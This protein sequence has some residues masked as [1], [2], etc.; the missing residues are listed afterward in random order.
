MRGQKTFAAAWVVCSVTMTLS[1]QRRLFAE[2]PPRLS[3]SSGVQLPISAHQTQVHPAPCGWS[4]VFDAGHPE[5]PPRLVEA[6]GSTECTSGNK[7]DLVVPAAAA[8]SMTYKTEEAW[9]SIHVIALEA[10]SVGD[11]IRCRSSIDGAVLLG[12]I[13]DAQTVEMLFRE[14]KVAW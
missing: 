1:L 5:R 8:L 13:A 3:G 11:V 14:R 9:A 4:A 2:S 12:R 7:R 6:T 10:G